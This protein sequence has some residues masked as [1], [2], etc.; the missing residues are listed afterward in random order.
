[1]RDGDFTGFPRIIDPLTGAPFANNQIPVNRIDSR[2]QA[3][4]IASRC[5]TRPVRRDCQ[6]FA[7]NI[8]N[9]SDIN[10]YFVRLDHRLSST[11][12]SS[13]ATST[14]SKGD[15][16]LRRAGLPAGYGSW[17][18]GGFD[19]KIGNLTWTRNILADAC[20]TRR[21]LATLYHGPSGWA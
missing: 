12:T 11:A 8:K 21:A 18:N 6:Q 20:S 7:V 13:G 19:T 4:W 17:E 14:S 15:P 10:R 2:A 5:R 9:D 3:C 1:M 16:V